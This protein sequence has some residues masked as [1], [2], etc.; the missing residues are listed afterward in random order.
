MLECV[1]EVEGDGRDWEE[2]RVLRSARAAA[3]SRCSRLRFA[4]IFYRLCSAGAGFSISR[5]LEAPSGFTAK[6]LK[7]SLVYFLRKR[8]TE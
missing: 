8:S 2:S 3:T 7:I 4:I 5:D 6:V 1:E